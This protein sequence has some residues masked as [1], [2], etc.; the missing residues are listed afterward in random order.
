MTG[1]G[2]S[3]NAGSYV[4][5]AP[6]DPFVGWLQCIAVTPEILPAEMNAIEGEAVLY[7]QT[8]EHV[9]AAEYGAIGIQAIAGASDG[10]NSLLVGTEYSGCPNIVTFDHFFD[11]AIEPPSG[12]R[13]VETT[14][15][16]VPCSVDFLR[17]IHPTT[18]LEYLVFT[19]FGQRFLIRSSTFS[20]LASPLSLLDGPMRESSPFFAG[21]AGTLTGKTRLR[22]AQT[23]MLGIAIE[24]HSDLAD[25][26]R[27]SRAAFNLHAQGSRA[28]VDTIVL[29]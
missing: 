22:S 2:G 24:E 6:E 16:L 20:M 3:S 13:A 8:A 23:G 29:P 27:K 4:P 21:V 28:T 9:D 19:E 18:N 25:P 12:A 5:P 26:S 7:E 1:P 15:A 10:D 11:G 14:L 17:Q